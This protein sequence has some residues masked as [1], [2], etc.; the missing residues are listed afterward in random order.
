M[1][2]SALAHMSKCHKEIARLNFG[3]YGVSLVQ[4]FKISKRE[5]YPTV[6]TIVSTKAGEDGSLSI[7]YTLRPI[8]AQR[9]RSHI[10]EPFGVQ[11][12]ISLFLFFFSLFLNVLLFSDLQ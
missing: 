3:G 4:H 8:T 7:H 10:K 12:S 1:V 2:C 11:R 5:F 6:S 9:H